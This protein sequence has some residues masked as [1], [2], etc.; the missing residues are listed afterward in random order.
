MGVGRVEVEM[1]E[2]KARLASLPAAKG[3]PQADMSK[4]EVVEFEYEDERHF[5]EIRASSWG[6]DKDLVR[7]SKVERYEDDEGRV[8]TIYDLHS[9]A[10]QTDRIFKMYVLNING[11]PWHPTSRPVE[12]FPGP[13]INAFMEAFRARTGVETAL[14]EARGKSDAP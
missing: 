10:S 11:S 8:R 14:G 1:D 2:A 6:M 5:V 7:G 3:V 9:F 13:W 12:S 4:T